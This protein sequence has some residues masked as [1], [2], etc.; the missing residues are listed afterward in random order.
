MDCSA[1]NG[2]LPPGLIQLLP[3]YPPVCVTLV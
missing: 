2:V 3:A 1:L